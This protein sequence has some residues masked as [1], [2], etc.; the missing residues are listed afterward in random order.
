MKFRFNKEVSKILDNL[1][2]PRMYFN[3]EEEMQ[4]EDETLRKAIKEDYNDFSEKM[5][6]KLEPYKDEINQFYQKDIYSH[7]DFANILIH[8][9]PIYEYS[10]IDTYFND[11][12]KEET[13]I[14]KDKIIKALITMEDSDDLT[15]KVFDESNATQFINQLKIDSSNK[16]NLFMM[17]QNPHQHLEKY[18]LL[19][20][21]IESFFE[22]SYQNYENKCDE[23]GND[24]AKRLSKNTNETFKKI[25]YDAI[26]YEFNGGEFCDFYVSFV[27]PYTLRF[28]E[29]DICRMVWG[30][31]MEYSFKKIHELNEDKLAQRVKIFKALGDK[32]RYETLRLI[33]KGVSSIK[34]I[35]DEL[36]V[37][38]ATISYHIN[39]FLTSGILFMSRDKNQKFGYI[40]DYKKLSEVFSDFKEDLNFK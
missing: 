6:S 31:E 9:Y 8:A 23:V 2:F 38:S 1:V 37:S 4:N 20:K 27:M 13:S 5:H 26:S 21:K 12:M 11:L 22:S 28:I 15:T 30:L 36:D 39:E 3:L 35:A 29:S 7:Y 18:I 24:L 32:T 16:W 19:F 25:T 34:N 33:A 17:I 10:D 40:V 14:L